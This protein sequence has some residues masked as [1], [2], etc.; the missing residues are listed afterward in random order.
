MGYMFMKLFPPLSVSLT[1]GK[2]VAYRINNE[3]QVS[4][5]SGR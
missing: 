4:P 5:K 3:E 1:F 2:L